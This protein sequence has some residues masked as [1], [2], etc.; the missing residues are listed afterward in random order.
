MG[1]VFQMLQKL[2]KE[3]DKASESAKRPHKAAE[4]SGDP[5]WSYRD[6]QDPSG[7]QWSKTRQ[8][9]H[10]SMAIADTDKQPK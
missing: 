7:R 3:M 10:T 1:G 8:N 2:F 9:K 6:A 4:T 5:G